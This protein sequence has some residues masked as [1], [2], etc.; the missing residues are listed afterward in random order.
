MK[1]LLLATLVLGVVGC[2]DD[3]T[4]QTTDDIARH[5]SSLRQDQR[6]PNPTGYAAT[7]SLNGSVDLTDDFFQSFGTNGRTCGSC[8]VPADGWTIIPSELQQRFEA[9]AGLD[10]VFR[11]NDGSTSPDDD[12]STKA[13]RR[14]A[15]SMLLTK[16]LIRVGIGIPMNAEFSLQAVDD[17]YHHANASD[18]SLFRRPL[19]SA[20]LFFLSTVMWDGRETLTDA[21]AKPGDNCISAP[22]APKCFQPIDNDLGDQAIGA[23]LGHAQAMVPG[24]TPEQDRA[25]VDFEESLMFAQIRDNHAGKLDRRGANGGPDEIASTPGYFGENDNFGDFRTHQP[26]TPEIFDLYTAW[27]DLRGGDYD[28]DDDRDYCDH[29]GGINAAREQVARGEAIFNNKA[30]TISGV[31]GLNNSLGLP[32]SFSGTCGTCHDLPNAGNHSVPVPLDIGLVGTDRRTADMPLYTLACN[33]TGVA[34]GHCTAGQTVQVTDPGRALITGNFADIGRFKGPTLRGLS[35]RAP[36]FHNGSAADLGAVVDFYDTRF[37]IGFT[38][39][40]RADL[41]AF[42]Q[43]L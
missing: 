30:I 15:Y 16:G 21:V 12:V 17:P 26:F 3:G 41:I 39:Q 19:P 40:E 20:N 24:L 28:D 29:H 2:V 23:T 5:K 1:P 37:G 8:H 32:A 36:Y 7:F 42:L 10:P 38:H 9:T 31:G 13:K 27:T 35:S 34:A 14:I 11:T 22:F 25:I 43:T 33:A 18:L 4:Q 6:F